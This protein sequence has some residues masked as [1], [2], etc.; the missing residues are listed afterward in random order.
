M[1][2]NRFISHLMD[3]SLIR[4]IRISALT[5]I[6]STGTFHLI[7]LYNS[8]RFLGIMNCKGFCRNFVL[9]LTFSVYE[10]FTEVLCTVFYKILIKYFESLLLNSF[11]VI[12]VKSKKLWNHIE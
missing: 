3:Q 7:S 10:Y 2:S 9:I 5:F 12:P 11:C 6:S 4:I 8:M 1:N